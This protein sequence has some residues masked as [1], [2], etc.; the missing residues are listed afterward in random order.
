MYLITSLSAPY[1]IAAMMMCRI[2][3]KAD[4]TKFSIEWLPLIDA[5]VSAT[6]MNWS[7]I[8][9]DNLAM[10]ISKYRQK[11]SVSSIIFPPFYM[12]AYVMDAICFFSQ[13][14]NMGWK[15]IVQNPLPIHVY[16]KI[17]WESQFHPHFYKIC[18]GITLPIHKT[19]FLIE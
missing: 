4:S 10:V 14:P 3:R 8:L 6:I 19:F 15:W 7:Q 1:N 13:F 2:F 12:S 11:R 9:F 17:L 16:Y 18:Q 5:V